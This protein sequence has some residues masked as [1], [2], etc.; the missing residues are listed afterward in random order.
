MSTP[1]SLPCIYLFT[2][3]PIYLYTSAFIYFFHRRLLADSLTP[4]YLFHKF[5]TAV[6]LYL[7]NLSPVNWSLLL[8]HKTTA[9]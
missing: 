2:Y 6:L 4:F 1:A 3:I 8:A 7:F 5:S 9:L